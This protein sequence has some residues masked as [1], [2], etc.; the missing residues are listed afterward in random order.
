MV[1]EVECPGHARAAIRSME[2]RYE[3]YKQTDLAKATEYRLADPDD[4]S[5]Y[6]SAQGYHDNVM[7]PGLPSSLTFMKKVID[8]VLLM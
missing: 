6:T 5:Q 1:P 8:E 2:A 3:K 4:A 7:D